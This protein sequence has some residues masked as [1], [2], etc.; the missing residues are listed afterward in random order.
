MAKLMDHT[1]MVNL[2]RKKKFKNETQ[3]LGPGHGLFNVDTV[4]RAF[5]H[6]P[7][8]KAPRAKQSPAVW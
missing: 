7:H 8:A 3:G 5:H 6:V 1:F 4:T 2:T